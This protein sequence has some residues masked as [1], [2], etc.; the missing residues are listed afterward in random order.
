MHFYRDS[1]KNEID[2]V[3]E[4]GDHLDLFEIEMRKNLGKKDTRV[5]DA[6][7]PKGKKVNR[8]LVSCWEHEAMIS[9]LTQNLPWWRIWPVA[10]GNGI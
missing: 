4:S 6:M 1:N 2:L 7:A 8:K 5:M 3:L 9:R 10:L